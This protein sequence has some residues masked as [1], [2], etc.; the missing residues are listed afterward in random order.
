MDESLK[1]T[2]K[3]CKNKAQH[4]LDKTVNFSKGEFVFNGKVVYDLSYPNALTAGR[5]S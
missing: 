4:S 1:S 5:D 2:L 3:N